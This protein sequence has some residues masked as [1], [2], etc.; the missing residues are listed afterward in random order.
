MHEKGAV[1]R[2]RIRMSMTD[3]TAPAAETDTAETSAPGSVGDLLSSR[4]QRQAAHEAHAEVGEREGDED[5][6]EAEAPAGETTTAPAAP[7]AAAPAAGADAV[8]ADPASDP[9]SPK[10]FRE[11]M[12]KTAREASELRAE[13]ERLRTGQQP[14]TAPPERPARVLPNPSE[15]PEGFANAV[16]AQQREEMQNYQLQTTL[17]LS[18]RFLK[19]AHGA[20]AFDEVFAWLDTRQDLQPVFTQQPDPWGAAYAHYQ[21]E[22]L[23]EEIGDDPAAYR[24]RI[25]E[26]AIAR[27]KASQEGGEQ[28]PAAPA[29]PQMGRNP[30]PPA[31]QVRSAAP[32][33]PIGRFTGPAPLKTRNNFG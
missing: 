33:D 13:N 9:R 2:R 27:F 15:D 6:D 22:K 31:S 10:W 29:R 14:R 19:Q 28:A 32:R 24:K 25:E 12:K 21:R 26:E 30:P 3:D 1:E 11:H 18:A 23:A 5:E 17:D 4:H 8:E 20:E 7:A 16:F